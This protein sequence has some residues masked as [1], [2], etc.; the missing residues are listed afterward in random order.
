MRIYGV[1]SDSTLGKPLLIYL[2]RSQVFDLLPSMQQWPLIT[3]LRG[4][5]THKA[6]VK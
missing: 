3:M 2:Y 6:T 4:F 1:D 5:R